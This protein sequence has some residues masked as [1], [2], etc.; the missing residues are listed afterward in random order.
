MDETKNCLT[1]RFEP[2]WALLSPISPCRFGSCR[3]KGFDVDMSAPE[4]R[5]RNYGGD[6][7]FLHPDYLIDDCPAYEPR[8][9]IVN[10]CHTIGGGLAVRQV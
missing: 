5:I 2:E 7:T 4:N 6:C 1:C 3:Y 8:I 10:P 9:S